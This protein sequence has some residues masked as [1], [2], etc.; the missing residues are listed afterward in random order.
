M[1][2]AVRYAAWQHTMLAGYL[3]IVEAVPLGAWN[4]QKGERLLPALL[5]GQGIA[6]DEVG[7]LA[8]VTLPAVLC[9]VAL[10]RRSAWFMGA[11]LLVDAVWLWMQIQTWWVPYVSGRPSKWQ[12]AYAHGPTTRVL[13]S[14]G[15]HVAPDGMHLAIHVLL[16]A[17]M[18]TGVLA[19]RQLVS[20]RALTGAGDVRSRRTSGCS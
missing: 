18:I 19:A 2:D 1:T 10:R 15:D 16:V 13:P 11:T 5:N 17:A 8:F 6:A 7:T 3:W 12:L 4:H 14:F 9:W 20:A